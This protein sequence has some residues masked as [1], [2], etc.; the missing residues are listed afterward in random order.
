M[1][2]SFNGTLAGGATCDFGRRDTDLLNSSHI[3]VEIGTT[4]AEAVDGGVVFSLP[5]LTEL[6]CA[7]E[8]MID[9]KTAVEDL[10]RL[11]PA[12][13]LEEAMIARSIVGGVK[14]RRKRDAMD[15]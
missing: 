12:C 5:L 15:G 11:W 7:L 10:L 2:L 4:L 1:V 14:I 9:L 8:P 13:G 6:D 3:G